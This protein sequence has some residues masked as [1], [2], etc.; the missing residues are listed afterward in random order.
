MRLWHWQT[1][2]ALL[3]VRG[4][5]VTEIYLKVLVYLGQQQHHVPLLT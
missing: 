4:I 5:K 1:K 2:A 3:L